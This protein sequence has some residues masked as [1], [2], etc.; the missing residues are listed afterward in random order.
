[1]NNLKLIFLTLITEINQLANAGA[2]NTQTAI[3]QAL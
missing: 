2:E 3:Y 1:M